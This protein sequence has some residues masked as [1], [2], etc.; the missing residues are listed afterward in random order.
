MSGVSG[1]EPISQ[2]W[3]LLVRPVGILI[4]AREDSVGELISTLLRE[5][6]PPIHQ[7]EKKLSDYTDVPECLLI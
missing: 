5:L 7:K 6:P 4:G 2:F 3:E 1:G